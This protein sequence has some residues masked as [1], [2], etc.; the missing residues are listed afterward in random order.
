MPHV[1]SSPR[2]MALAIMAEKKLDPGA[3]VQAVSQMTM[4]LYAD[5]LDDDLEAIRQIRKFLD[6]W[7]RDVH[8]MPQSEVH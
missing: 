6:G 4:Q 8:A 1:L 3:A 2:S 5:L 7:E